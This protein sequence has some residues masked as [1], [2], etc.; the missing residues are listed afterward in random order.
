MGTNKELTE[1]IVPLLGPLDVELWDLEHTGGVVRLTV[2]REGGIDLDAIA[3]VTRAVSRAL[4]EADPIG[5]KY[6]LEVSSP[7]VERTLRTPAHYRRSIGVTVRIKTVPAFEGL[8]RITGD[9][10]DA[11]ESGITVNLTGGDAE[12]IVA[13][14]T[15]GE[16][17]AQVRLAYGD[18]ERARTVFTWG[19]AA[20]AEGPSGR[21]SSAKHRSGGS[22]T[23]GRERKAAS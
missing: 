5:G 13:A 6:T 10:V 23:A 22:R 14:E 21:G 1:L 4:D 9:L 2:D 11:D 19:A 16:G 17:P 7:G 3:A 20:R 15:A 8:R 12:A 18:I